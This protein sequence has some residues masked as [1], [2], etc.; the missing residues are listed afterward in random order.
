MT[1]EFKL[2]VPYKKKLVK[3]SD[4]DMKILFDYNNNKLHTLQSLG[5]KYGITR[6]RVRQILKKLNHL[7]FKSR[8]PKD[9]TT[10]KNELAANIVVSEIEN[11]LNNYYGDGTRNFTKWKKRFYEKANYY[12]I[13][14]FKRILLKCWQQGKLD[15]LDYIDH[16]FRI[17]PK[18][19]KILNLKGLGHTHDEVAKI[20]NLSKPSICNYLR[21]CKV[22]GLY[23]AKNPNQIKAASLN[24][25]DIESRLNLIRRG[26][27]AG[28]SLLQI[29]SEIYQRP[30]KEHTQIL[31]HFIVRHHTVP[32]MAAAF[33][34]EYG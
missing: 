7:G 18:H 4:R 5:D 26:M 8:N 34:R 19:Y 29:E 13:K 31:N 15:P 22:I 32:K 1:S 25:K 12:Q 9:R 30:E 33:R 14:I 16:Q 17:T 10:Y 3:I 23:K 21:S 28:K 20:M 2:N 24:K 11:A 27:K 6:E